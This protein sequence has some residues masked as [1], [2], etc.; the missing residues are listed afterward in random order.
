MMAAAALAIWLVAGRTA[1]AP[2]TAPAASVPVR[3]GAPGTMRMEKTGP[4]VAADRGAF[5]A[6]EARAYALLGR[7]ADGELAGLP[8][9]LD[10]DTR[11]ACARMRGLLD[12]QRSTPGEHRPTRT[13]GGTFAIAARPHDAAA[14][15]DGQAADPVSTTG[16]VRK[17][18]IPDA[19]AQ[20]GA[21]QAAEAVGPGQVANDLDFVAHPGAVVLDGDEQR[22]TGAGVWAALRLKPGAGLPTRIV[23]QGEGGYAIALYG[24]D[25]GTVRV[26]GGLVVPG[27][28]YRVAGSVEITGEAPIDVHVRP[29]SAVPEYHQQPLPAPSANG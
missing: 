7:I 20:P 17:D 29:L 11:A 28:F 9:D 27:R 22:I 10:A 4:A 5:T 12:R 8:A 26:N 23:D 19:S 6:A 2:Q 15:V 3:I 1:P 25:F 18:G 21:G 16:A 13:P 14:A 24:P